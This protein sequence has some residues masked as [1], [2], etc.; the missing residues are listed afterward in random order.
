M[1][2][3]FKSYQNLESEYF[4]FKQFPQSGIESYS[5]PFVHRRREYIILESA[6]FLD[7]YETNFLEI[8]NRSGNKKK[9]GRK[10]IKPIEELYWNRIENLHK[11]I[12]PL[13]KTL[14]RWTGC[15]LAE[16]PARDSA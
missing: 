6:S 1:Y 7:E 11:I 3:L 16:S 5:N 10:P 4:Q 13:L 12:Y 14:N 2:I 8:N 15:F 9:K